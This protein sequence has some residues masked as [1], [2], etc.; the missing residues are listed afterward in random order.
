LPSHHFLEHTGETRLLV[1]GRTLE[2]VFAEA[3]LAFGDLERESLHPTAET[4]YGIV[5]V[6]SGDLP[7][8]LVD[9][10][11]ELIYWCET[12]RAV[13]AQVSPTFPSPGR[14]EA[15]VSGP[16]LAHRPALVKAATH[17]GLRL[18]HAG[19]GWEAEVVLDV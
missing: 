4:A 7:A 5:Q 6:E 2:E 11:N 10:L 18:E 13:P 3:A 8:L 15:R 1:R 19:D 17:H 12:E 16:R 14:L 9:W